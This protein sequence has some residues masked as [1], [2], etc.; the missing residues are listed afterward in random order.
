MNDLMNQV[1]T[2]EEKVNLAKSGFQVTFTNDDFDKPSIVEFEPNVEVE[3]TIL[4]FDEKD[5][6]KR[7]T[8]MINTGSKKDSKHQLY[9]REYTMFILKDLLKAFYTKEDLI[10]NKWSYTD[11]IGKTFTCIPMNRVSTKGKGYQTLTSVKAKM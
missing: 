3:M 4:N 10:Q 1:F 2:A 9:I 8:C 6:W 7:Y 5:D 11:L